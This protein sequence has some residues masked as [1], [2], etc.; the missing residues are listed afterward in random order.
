[1]PYTQDILEE[2]DLLSRY[3]LATTLEGIKVHQH[4]APEPMIAATQRLFK[5]GLITQEDGGYLTSLG[6]KAAEHTQAAL[7]ILK[8]N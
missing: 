7:L 3:N 6:R 4:T 1:M 2:L 8:P 5:K